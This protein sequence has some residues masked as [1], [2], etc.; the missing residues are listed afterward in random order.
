VSHARERS[1]KTCLN[2]NTQLFGRFCHVCGQEN[3]EPRESFWSVITHF[4]NDLTHFDGKFFTTTGLL[5]SKPGFLP[6]EYIRGRRAR[7]LH[8]IRLYLFTSAV[9]FF[10]LYSFT[11]DLAVNDSPVNIDSLSGRLARAPRDTT[12]RILFPDKY[13]TV[14]QYDSTQKTLAAKDRDNWLKRMIMVS[15]IKKNNKYSGRPDMMFSSLFN[16][17][18][19][20]FPYLLFVALPVSAFFLELLYVR[21]RNSLYAGHAIFLVYLYVFTYMMLIV[22]YALDR[23]R[24][25][26]NLSWLGYLQTAV[27]GYIGIYSLIAMKRYYGERWRTTIVKFA[28]WNFLA[29]ITIIA[30]FVVFLLLTL[31][32]D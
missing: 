24:D 22:Y 13:R 32:R 20:S 1:E 25:A 5:I 27:I 3:I 18:I 28:V 30:L 17:F 6:L 4:F 15:S 29:F 26:F 16:K 2:C 8:P 11:S 21:N 31:I 14:A 12:V 10:L 9:F 19:H 7:Y 23:L